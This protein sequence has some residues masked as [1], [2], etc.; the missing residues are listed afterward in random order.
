MIKQKLT[1]KHIDILK[2]YGITSGV[3]GIF[4]Q[5]YKRGEFICHQGYSLSSLSIFISGKAKVFYTSGDGKTMLIGFYNNTG[6]IGEV[7]FMADESEA[8]M[9]VQTITDSFCISIPVNK[10][11]DSLKKSS[12]FLNIV[13]SS[14]AGKLK[15]S[16]TYSTFNILNSLEKR[17]C[18]YIEMTNTD[19]FFKEKMTDVSELLGTSYRHLLRTL[20]KLC[21]E[22]VL[23]KADGGYFVI[24]MMTLRRMHGIEDLSFFELNPDIKK[25]I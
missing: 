23:K 9:S 15:Q 11:G 19:G 3:A 10:Y 1:G 2:Q 5:K 18:A 16:N 6:M 12:V 24:D 13:G 21:A 4:V 20:C 7:E 22:G 8:S 17:L 25:S 14:I